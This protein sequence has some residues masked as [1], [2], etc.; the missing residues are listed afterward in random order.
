M[1]DLNELTL[2]E[3]RSTLS[4]L[5]VIK[6]ESLFVDAVPVTRARQAFASLLDKADQSEKPV[7]LMDRGRPK[8]VIL[9]IEQ[10]ADL[11]EDRQ[12]LLHALDA[13]QEFAAGETV[14]LDE[15]LTSQS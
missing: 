15:L 2:R 13:L 7:L 8:S 1:L 11:L 3:L 10:Y 12:T 4:A 14:L 6:P 5:D 9:S